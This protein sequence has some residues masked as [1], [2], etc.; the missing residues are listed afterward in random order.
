MRK[1]PKKKTLF[2]AWYAYHEAQ[3]VQI[4]TS[5]KQI[6]KKSLNYSLTRTVDQVRVIFVG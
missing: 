5:K 4:K 1:T 6:L 2:Q 3:D